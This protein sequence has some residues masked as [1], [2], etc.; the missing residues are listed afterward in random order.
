MQGVGKN[1]MA[2]MGF[3][4][5]QLFIH[6]QPLFTHAIFPWQYQLYIDI[7]NLKTSLSN[8]D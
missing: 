2:I 4:L 3:Q 5:P 7:L 6:L 1:H 8:K